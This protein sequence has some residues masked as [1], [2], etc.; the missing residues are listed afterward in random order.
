VKALED[1]T[2]RADGLAMELAEI[3]QRRLPGR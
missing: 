2:H 3:R 1:A